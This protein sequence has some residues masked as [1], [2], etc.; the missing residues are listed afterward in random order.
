MKKD[1]AK[2]QTSPEVLSSPVM[3]PKGMAIA[4]AKGDDSTASSGHRR[5]E[6][7]VD[8]IPL[9]D[10]QSVGSS[11]IESTDNVKT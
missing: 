10:S 9:L 7:S 8:Q 1:V 2:W 5:G 6:S 11:G 4:Q 3:T